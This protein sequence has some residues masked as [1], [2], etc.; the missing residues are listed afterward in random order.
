LPIEDPRGLL[1]EI[2]DIPVR[3][4]IGC[5]D[6]TLARLESDLAAMKARADAWAVGDVDALRKLPLPE[7][8]SACLATLSNSARFRE[9]NDRTA[10]AWMQGAQDALASNASTLALKP[11]YELLG[12]NGILEQFRSMG[13]TVEGP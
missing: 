1:R 10:R 5:L 9:L 6:T 2:G 11:I 3:A 13:Y 8:Q 4:Q 7:Q 12:T